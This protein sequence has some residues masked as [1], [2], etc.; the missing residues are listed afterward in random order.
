VDMPYPALSLIDDADDFFVLL[1]GADRVIEL[2]D[3]S[4]G[5]APVQAC[6]RESGLRSLLG[7]R[8]YPFGKFLGVV[9][10]GSRKLVVYEPARLLIF[11]S[12][13]ERIAAVIDRTRQAR[14]KDELVAK[15]LHAQ[16]MGERFMG[17]LAH[18]LRNPLGSI[19]THAAVLE[20]GAKTIDTQTIGRRI[21][22]SGQRMGR[23]IEQLLDV[24]RIRLGGGLAL[25]VRPTDLEEL[26]RRLV[27]EIEIVHVDRTITIDTT[28]EC[29]GMWDPDRLSQAV[30]NLIANAVQ[31]G[32]TGTP[33]RV[34]V[35]GT[36]PDVVAFTV[37]NAGAIPE[38]RLER[39]FE[40]FS[41]SDLPPRAASGL[42]L[43]LY[44]ARE[45]VRR[46][47]GELT[48]DTSAATGFTRFDVRLPRRA[49]PATS[50]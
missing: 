37:E 20:H 6:L 33:I 32:T 30:S 10:I 25:A 38:D 4:A 19:V 15:L 46:H 17:V 48:V 47:G 12:L 42:G 39:L 13:V 35:D 11:S 16:Q 34:R 1:M 44:I 31:H 40:P 8:M 22:E 29:G 9:A 45:I 3:A 50:R 23:M 49:E 28:G 43:G 21:R 26:C 2:A 27:E 7:Q 18:D 5:G 14:A 41:G 24:S 36:A